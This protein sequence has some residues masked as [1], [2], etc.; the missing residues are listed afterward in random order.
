[1][2][3]YIVLSD[4]FDRLCKQAVKF[5]MHTVRLFA[6][7]ILDASSNRVYGK[8]FTNRRTGQ[9]KEYMITARWVQTFY[10]LFAS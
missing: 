9:E 6:L 2:K 1:M 4:A 5:N 7:I 8:G 10:E 3:L